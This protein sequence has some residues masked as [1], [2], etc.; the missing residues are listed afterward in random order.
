[1]SHCKV[2][3]E[4]SLRKYFA[5]K[6]QRKEFTFYNFMVY[7]MKWQIINMIIY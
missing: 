2:S 3:N 6:L 4:C 5:G 1:M 7:T